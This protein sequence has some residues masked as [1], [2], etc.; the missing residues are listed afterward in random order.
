M[1][2]KDFD[3]LTKA[4]VRVGEGRG[5]VIEYSKEYPPYQGKRMF[6]DER[7]VCTDD[8]CL[9]SYPPYPSTSHI[10]E[11][12]YKNLLGT[13]HAGSTYVWSECVFVDPIADI[14]ILDGADSQELDEQHD[15]Y[16]ELVE[17][18]APFEIG[19]SAAEGRV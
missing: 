18:V 1:T 11:R 17:N 13:L 9:P 19:R 4:V 2:N 5:F 8:H 6:V 7:L 3:V 15:A 14:A 10:H 12:T 16:L